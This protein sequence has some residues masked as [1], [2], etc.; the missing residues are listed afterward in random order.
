MAIKKNGNGDYYKGLLN[1][2]NDNA[3]KYDVVDNFEELPLKHF[4]KLVRAVISPDIHTILEEN[5]K[6]DEFFKAF[7]T[8]YLIKG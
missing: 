6:W 1:S 3:I 7:F 5:V 8:Q 4:E 2:L